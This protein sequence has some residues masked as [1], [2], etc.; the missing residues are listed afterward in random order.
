[1]RNAK[2]KTWLPLTVFLLAGA[3][4]QIFAQDVAPV[5]ATLSLSSDKKVSR[6]GEPIRVVMSFTSERDGY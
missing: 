5:R 6:A 2:S 4:G 1:M 3:A